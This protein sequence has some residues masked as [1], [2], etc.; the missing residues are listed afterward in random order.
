[1]VDAGMAMATADAANLSNGFVGDLTN[2]DERQGKPADDWTKWGRR[3][4]RGVAV[5]LSPTFATALA[6]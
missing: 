3:P 1:M 4:P 6:A 2:C 5:S